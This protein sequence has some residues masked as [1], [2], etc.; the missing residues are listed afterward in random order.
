MPRSCRLPLP[1]AIEAGR[2]VTMVATRFLGRVWL[3]C[4]A[5][6]NTILSSPF[7]AY[8]CGCWA[9][10]CGCLVSVWHWQVL[11]EQLRGTRSVGSL[12]VDPQ[13]C[14]CTATGVRYMD[15]AGIREK[16]ARRTSVDSVFR[17]SG[18]CVVYKFIGQ[19]KSTPFFSILLSLPSTY[20]LSELYPRFSTCSWCS[21][22]LLGSSQ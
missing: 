19:P 4:T 21:L 14:Y 18:L 1:E 7:V 15:G 3:Q 11:F 16:V 12:P 10:L 8:I 20:P 22:G 17:Y 2:R 9:M 13:C 6:S 5:H